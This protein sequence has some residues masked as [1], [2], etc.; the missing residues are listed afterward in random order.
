MD[1]IDKEHIPRLQGSEKT[2]Q[3]SGLVQHRAGSHLHIDSHLVGYDM[4]QR[5]LT[6][7]GRAMEQDMVQGF[8]TK[9][10]S[11]DIDSK[12]GYNLL[13]T[14]KIVQPLRAD[15]SVKF[16]IFALYCIVRIEFVHSGPDSIQI[17]I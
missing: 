4:G 9:L 10:G 13:L 14:G 8:T 2:R 12:I 17:Q 6:Q 7:T 15:N 3:V 1:F 5:S 11:L 16:I